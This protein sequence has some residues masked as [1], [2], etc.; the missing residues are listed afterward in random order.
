MKY[1]YFIKPVGMDGPIKIGSSA[2]P[3]DRLLDL[4]VWSPFPL[5]II[6]AAPG[7]CRDEKFLHTRFADLHSHR[8]WFRSSPGLRRTIERILAGETFRAACVD[9]VKVGSIRNQKRRVVTPERQVFIDYSAKIRKALSPHWTKAGTWFDPPDVQK[10]MNA[11][12][13]DYARR[14]SV[15]P[16]EQQMA[17]LNEFLADPKRH[18]VFVERPLTRPFNPATVEAYEKQMSASLVTIQ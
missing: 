9:L 8:E 17:R 18:G 10:I 1:V 12:K 7:N 14:A 3:A 15:A 16:S 2:V 11:W 5:E 13:G 6:G 4:S